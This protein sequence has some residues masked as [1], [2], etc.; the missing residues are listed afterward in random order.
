MPDAVP[1]DLVYDIS[2]PSFT[3]TTPL[4]VVPAVVRLL[5]SIA[6]GLKA[7]AIVTAPTGA[8]ANPVLEAGRIDCPTLRK[9]AGERLGLRNVRAGD[10][11]AERSTDA[12]VGRG[13]ERTRG[14]VHD[15]C[16]VIL[17]TSSQSADHRRRGSKLT[18]SLMSG[19]HVFS[20]VML[21]HAGA[22]GSASLC[23]PS[24]FV[25]NSQLKKSLLVAT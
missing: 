18:S 24:G 14:E 11:I 20:A 15:E 22:E 1:I 5:P 16:A 3:T 23:V 13:D 6:A 19:A 17:Y 4:A 12:V 25:T 2:I 10:A 21:T 7:P 9:R 8:L